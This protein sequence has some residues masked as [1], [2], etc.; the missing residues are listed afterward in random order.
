[1]SDFVAECRREWKRLRVPD[2]V[3]DEMAAELSADLSEAAAEGVSPEEV[4]GASAND[5]RSFAASWA[6]ERGV[7]ESPAPKSR[8]RAR[9][10]L[11]A[12]MALLSAAAIAA[13]VAAILAAPAASTSQPDLGLVRSPDGTQWRTDGLGP[14]VDASSF[15]PRRGSKII[16]HV[17]Y[18]DPTPGSRGVQ[19]A[20]TGRI[21]VQTVDLTPV[22]SAA[23]N[24]PPRW[25]RDTGSH[26]IAWALLIAGVVGVLV[27]APFWWRITRR[28]SYA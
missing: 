12:V 24:P 18:L 3:A 2:A 15:I 8:P 28:Q 9:S 6:V 4:L 21:G 22:L 19:D 27:T 26:A 7:I 13:G 20:A 1:M 11:L 17:T 25:P 23:N 16:R 14:G 10:L 5:P